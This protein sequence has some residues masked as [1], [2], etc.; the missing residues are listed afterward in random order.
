MK[1][2]KKQYLNLFSGVNLLFKRADKDAK[3]QLAQ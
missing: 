2:D 1:T 3:I